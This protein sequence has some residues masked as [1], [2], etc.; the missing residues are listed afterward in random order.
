VVIGEVGVYPAFA[1]VPSQPPIESPPAPVPAGGHL[2]PLGG[3]SRRV[4]LFPLG[5]RLRKYTAGQ[6]AADSRAAVNVALLAI[7]QGMACAMIAGLPVEA[8]GILCAAMGS[9]LGPVFAHSRHTNLGPT[10]ATALMVFSSL[11]A[12]SAVDRPVLLPILTLIAALA[13]TAGAL[14]RMADLIQYISRSVIVGY[15]TGAALLIMA[16]QL[17]EALGIPHQPSHGRAQTFITLMVDSVKGLPQA[18]LPSPLIA[19]ASMLIY[20]LLTR[21]KRLK[22]LPCF[23]ITLVLASG[24]AALMHLH[25][26]RVARLHAFSLSEL[27]LSFPDFTDSTTYDRISLLI[28]PALAVAFLAALEN[29]VMTKSLAGKS[30]DRPDLNQDMFGCGM[31]N[32]GSVF[33]GG[34]PVSGSLTRS[35]LNFNSGARTQV[36]SLLCGVLCAAGALALGNVVPLIPRPALAALIMC[37]TVSVIQPAHLRICLRATRSDAITV[38]VTFLS[39][40]LMPLY[41]AIFVGVA[42]SIVLYLRK[43]SRPSLVEY[44]FSPEG[45]LTERPGSRHRENPAISIVHVEGDLFFGAAELFR[46]Q[47]QQTAADPQL[48][49]IILRMKNARHLDATSVMALEELVEFLRGHERHLIISGLSKE[50]Y[51]VLRNAGMIAVIGRENLFVGSAQ[52]P[53]LSTRNAL[54]RAQSLLGTTRADVRIFYDPSKHPDN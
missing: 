22:R 20:F 17:P 9:L 31:A 36:S 48:R 52:N 32:L 35:V 2:I 39:S 8:T 21:S 49:V 11:A 46:T 38:V 34:L 3:I 47:I 43:A 30:G 40:L 33:L 10:N 51:R 42:T 13:L 16:S 25:G 26:W 15:L 23:A 6:F 54:K 44:E 45:M 14:M 19:G 28:G 27:S 41:V 53:N 4:R 18:T 50:V 29:S 37:L 1:A 7:P 5:D 12:F 24:L